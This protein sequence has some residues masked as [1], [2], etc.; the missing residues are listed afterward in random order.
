ME[1]GTKNFVIFA[2]TI[3]I[4]PPSAW[5]G[6]TVIQQEQVN[7]RRFERGTPCRDRGRDWPFP[8]NSTEGYIPKGE[9]IEKCKNPTLPVD[10]V[11]FPQAD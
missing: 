7:M 10:Q 2:C 11:E 6:W 9:W 1:K 8:T 5:L 3:V 4:A